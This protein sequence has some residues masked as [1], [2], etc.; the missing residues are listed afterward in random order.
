MHRPGA[1][2]RADG[3]AL[4][5]FKHRVT[6]LRFSFDKEK[7]AAIPISPLPVDWKVYDVLLYDFR[8]QPGQICMSTLLMPL[9]D[10]DF[11]PTE[12]GVPWRTMRDHGHRVV[13]AT[14][15]RPDGT[16][17]SENGDRRGARHPF[18]ASEGRCQRAERISGDGA[19]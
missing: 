14:L 17:R 11:D 4:T 16:C 8:T 6:G 19:R 15:V 1:K 18:T 7:A 2:H 13:F 9:P 10:S 5:L 3:G 12:S